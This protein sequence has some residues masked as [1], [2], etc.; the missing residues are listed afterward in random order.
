MIDTNIETIY[1]EISKLSQSDKIILLSR[2]MIELTRNLEKKQKIDFYNI[3]GIGKEIWEDIDA[4]EYVNN[5][6]ASWE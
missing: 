6:R 4:Q 1:R 2:L 3:K 5:E